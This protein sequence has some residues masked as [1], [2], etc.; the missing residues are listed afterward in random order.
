MADMSAVARDLTGGQIH[1]T[2][3]TLLYAALKPVVE[4]SDLFT[5]QMGYVLSMLVNNKKRKPCSLKPAEHASFYLVQA[6]HAERSEKMQYIRKL[7]MERSFVYMFLQRVLDTYYDT[8][9]DSYSAMLSAFTTGDVKEFRRHRDR[10]DMHARSIGAENRNSMYYMLVR[11]NRAL[12]EFKRFFNGIVSNF[13]NMCYQQAQEYVR[14]NPGRQYDVDD[15]A[16]N[17]FRGVIIGLNKYDSSRGAHTTYITWWLFNAQTC[18]SAEHEYGIAYVIPQSQVKRLA[19]KS[20]SASSNFSVSLDQNPSG[21]DDEE[22]SSM[23]SRLGGE[24]QD[25]E[26]EVGLRR[27]SVRIAEVAKAVDPFG[28]WRVTADIDE[29]FSANEIQKMR[30]HM[31]TQNL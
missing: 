29:V 30:E 5:A 14:K 2:M 19:G 4:N 20:N 31:A 26:R 7:R 17:F 9:M 3:D 13:T 23:H 10:V 21:D 6:L 8:F 15:V 16:Q 22:G 18:G 11:V 12:P 28:I 25:L 1:E 24:S 27:Q